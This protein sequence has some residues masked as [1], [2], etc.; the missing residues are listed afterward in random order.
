MPVMNGL[1]AV[2]ILKQIMPKVVLIMYSASDT[3]VCKRVT[4][5]AGIS[6]LVSKRHKVSVLIETA[7]TLVYQKA[8]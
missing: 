7:R 1:S 2:R 5:S 6:G 4:L 3:E 8:A